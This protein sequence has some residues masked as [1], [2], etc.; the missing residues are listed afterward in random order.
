MFANDTSVS[1][2]AK[3]IE[4]LQSV[5]SSELENLHKLLNKNKLRLTKHFQ[6]RFMIIGVSAMISAVDD[7]IIIEINDC[8][9]EKINLP[10]VKSRSESIH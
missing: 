4:E 10:I 8:E 7:R 3:A 9:L 6:N 5:M 2:A 1:Y